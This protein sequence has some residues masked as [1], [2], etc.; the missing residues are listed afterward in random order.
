MRKKIS[1]VYKG[2]KIEL[3]L[4]KKNRKLRERERVAKIA[5]E[6]LQ[7]RKCHCLSWESEKGKR[8]NMANLLI[9]Q[10]YKY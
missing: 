2:L 3:I 1:S 10:T 7:E 8:L 9:W 6:K 5:E 4:K